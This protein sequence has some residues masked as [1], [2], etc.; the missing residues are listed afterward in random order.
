[1]EV[2]LV[3]DLVKERTKDRYPW[4]YLEESCHTDTVPSIFL[5]STLVIV[6]KSYIYEI[7]MFPHHHGLVHLV[8]YG[9]HTMHC[10]I[11]QH[12]V[13]QHGHL[14]DCPL[15]FL[16]CLRKIRLLRKLGRMFMSCH[17]QMM[18]ICLAMLV[19]VEWVQSLALGERRRIV[20]CFQRAQSLG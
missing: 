2:H 13:H 4:S 11:A 17:Q 12:H 20:W 1:M 9:H 19:S 18:M 10:N 5:Q 6:S 7:L 8:P 16:V 15:L 14:V 3:D